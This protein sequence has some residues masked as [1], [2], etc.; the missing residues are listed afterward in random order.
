LTTES[1]LTCLQETLELVH[2]GHNKTNEVSITALAFPDNETTTFLVGTEEGN[3]YQ[4]NRYDR[5]GAKAGLNPH[6]IYRAHAGPI[7]GLSFHPTAGP[8]DFGDLVLSCSVD[9][10]C[11]LWRT[12]GAGAGAGAVGAAKSANQAPTMVAPVYSFE[13]ADDY[14]YD[15]KWHPTHPALFGSVDGSGRFDLWNLNADTEVC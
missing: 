6:D 4:A 7:T 9:W 11:K 14:V 5:A 2:S 1:A 12:R 10:T 3:I 8:V 13:E 15:V